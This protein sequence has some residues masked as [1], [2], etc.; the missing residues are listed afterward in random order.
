MRLWKRKTKQEKSDVQTMEWEKKKKVCM[1][2]QW[3]IAIEFWCENE[4]SDYIYK[5]TQQRSSEWES[6]RVSECVR[7]CLCDIY[8]VACQVGLF[9]L[10]V[11]FPRPSNTFLT[12]KHVVQFRLLKIKCSWKTLD[13]EN[14]SWILRSKL[15]NACIGHTLDPRSGGNFHIFRHIR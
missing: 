9:I 6:A 10:F 3:F 1:W 2:S 5:H 14:V 7:V 13:R 12:H 8:F 15:A 4:K 11:P